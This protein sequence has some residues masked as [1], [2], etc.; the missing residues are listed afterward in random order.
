MNYIRY[1]QAL[2]AV[3]YLSELQNKLNTDESL[4]EVGNWGKGGQRELRFDE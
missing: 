3:S 1:R 4:V 2:L